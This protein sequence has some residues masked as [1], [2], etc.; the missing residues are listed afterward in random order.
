MN[1][2]CKMGSASFL[3]VQIFADAAAR[4]LG[5]SPPAKNS[6]KG[7]IVLTLLGMEFIVNGQLTPDIR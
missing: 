7:K 1:A 3:A 4:F 2:D 6:H 5:N